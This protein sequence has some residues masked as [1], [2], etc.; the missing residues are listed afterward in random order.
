MRVSVIV[1]WEGEGVA[2][3]WVEVLGETK[4]R[5]S[6]SV[7]VSVEVEVVVGMA[8]GSLA[9]VVAWEVMGGI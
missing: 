6:G 8:H 3:L 2:G 1:G 5:D 9:Y 7:S 4:V